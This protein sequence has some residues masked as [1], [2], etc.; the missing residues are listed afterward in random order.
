MRKARSR[1]LRDGKTDGNGRDPIVQT[2]E[3]ALP[4][5]KPPAPLAE[6]KM[7][8]QTPTKVDVH[9][10]ESESEGELYGLTRG[11][12]KRGRGRLSRS[13]FPTR[14]DF[15]VYCRRKFHPQPNTATL[16]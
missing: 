8:A 16:M 3:S 2:A 11:F 15:F 6:A 12:V 7:I 4:P 13:I 5:K 10:F 9:I 14:E 1:K